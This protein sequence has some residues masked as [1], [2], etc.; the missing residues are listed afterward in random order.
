MS[1]SP[2]VVIHSASVTPSRS[3]H[4]DSATWPGAVAGSMARASAESAGDDTPRDGSLRQPIPSA[5]PRGTSQNPRRMLP[6]EYVARVRCQSELSNVTAGS[7][8]E[9][10]YLHMRAT[11]LFP[12]PGL[13]VVAV[14]GGPDS[15]ALLDLLATL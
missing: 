7:L 8:A 11:G 3:C 10:L 5:A 6:T 14:S 12:D 4:S 15:V 2:R 13:A 1:S 9:R